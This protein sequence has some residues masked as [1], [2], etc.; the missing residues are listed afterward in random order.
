MPWKVTYGH[1]FLCFIFKVAGIIIICLTCMIEI[2]VRL[3][4][5]GGRLGM[6]ELT[7]HG[8]PYDLVHV[9]MYTPRCI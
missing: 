3:V 7:A 5:G 6:Q 4:C 1:N 8:I 2:L 9:G